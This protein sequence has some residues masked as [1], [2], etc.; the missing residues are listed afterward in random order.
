[1]NSPH[2]DASGPRAIAAGRDIGT[3]ITGDVLT[4]PADILSAARDVPAPPGLSNLAPYP[5][6]L[7][8]EDALAW[9][10]AA[11]TEASG[12]AITQASTVHGLGGVGKTTLALAYAHRH[13]QDYTVI[14]WINADSPTRIEQSLADLALRLFTAWAGHASQAER[15]AWAMTWLQWHPG[16]LL[17]FDNVAS[18]ADVNSY[19]GALS[20]GHELISSRRA[21]GWPHTIRTYPLSTLGP[22]EAAEVLCTYALAGTPP[23]TRQLQEAKTLVAELGNLPSPWNRLAPIST[24]TPPSASTPTGDACLRTW[25]RPPRAPTPSA[26]SPASGPRPSDPSPPA[27]HSPSPSCAHWRGSLPMTSRS[28]FSKPRVWPPRSSTKPLAFCPPTAWP[29]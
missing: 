14:W 25:T 23:T 2:P 12:S 1:M 19:L 28:A 18:P 10:R 5:L 15:A 7:G 21:T 3:A 4:L 20:G 17:I 22:D 6:C 13:R 24:N 9:L 8:R 29:R 16:W 27:T 26:P 11:L